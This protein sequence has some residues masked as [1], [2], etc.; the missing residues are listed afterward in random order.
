MPRA[1]FYLIDRPR[2]RAEPL[3]L[4]CELARR[5][6]EADRPMLIL[7]RSAEQA[8]AL[9]DLLWAF[10]PEAYVPHQIAGD[11]DDD[12]TPVLIVPPGIATPDRPL[13]VNL[14]DA[15]VEGAFEVVKEVVPAEPAEREGARRR[16]REYQ[17]R[18]VEV[19]KHDL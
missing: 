7:V 13:V 2:F 14:R 3:L 12:V 15:C 19:V 16:W 5:A 6:V 4:V 18:G 10:D 11:E 8:E 17:R 9:D 1:E